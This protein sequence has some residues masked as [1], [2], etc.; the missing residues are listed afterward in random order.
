MSIAIVDSDA[1]CARGPLPHGTDAPCPLSHGR[2][3][4]GQRPLPDGRGSEKASGTATDNRCR[5][6]GVE[7][8]DRLRKRLEDYR[9]R[10]A[11]QAGWTQQF[12]PTGLAAVDAALP[13]GGLPCGA[14]TEILSDDAGVGAM[15]LALRIARQ[16]GSTTTATGKLRL[17]VP[18]SVHSR[19]HQSPDRKG[20][21]QPHEQWNSSNQTAATG[22]GRYDQRRSA[23]AG[24]PPV[25]P[26][27]LSLASTSEDHGQAVLAH[28][29]QPA[30][31]Y[32]DTHTAW[33]LSDGRG[34]DMSYPLPHGRG[35][36][37]HRNSNG[38]RAV[39][40][41]A[42]ARGSDAPY[43]LP[44]DR[45]SD[46]RYPLSDPNRHRNGSDGRHFVV[47]VDTVGDFYPPAAAQ[48]GVDLQRLTVVRVRRGK[49]AF[50]AVEQA[51]RCRAV[52][53]VIAPLPHL[54]ESQSRRLQLAAES[55]G[56]IG[57]ILRPARQRTKSFAAVRMHITGVPT[58]EGQLLPHTETGGMG[59]RSL[60][61]KNRITYDNYSAFETAATGGDRYIR[62][63]GSAT[64]QSGSITRQAGSMTQQ[65]GL[66]TTGATGGLPASV[67][68][69]DQQFRTGSELPVAPD[70]AFDESKPG[71][72]RTKTTGKLRLPMPP[73]MQASDRFACHNRDA[74]RCRIELL[75]VR[76][77]MPVEPILVDLHHE[78][79]DVPVHPVPVD[80][81][82][83]RTG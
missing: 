15:T 49:E 29:T 63:A 19:S 52:G 66:T 25:A 30:P 38:C 14:V 75:T 1:V 11:R 3:T 24:E 62:Q 74:Y 10:R 2:G 57:L 83:A 27:E 73:D 72:L 12:V 4:D 21:D 9:R 17:P 60:P 37:T 61:V 16:V 70:T 45:G 32:T 55:T 44:D 76:E 64:R 71:T 50:W 46:M 31:T 28:A 6:Q 78:T 48:H 80:R 20:G 36:D 69:G 56:C 22:G 43:P 5:D 26:H 51:L 23:L 67:C 68:S 47:V 35:S 77:G 39:A 40:P 81:P 65:A 7:V 82:A 18:P 34:T 8:V 53:A 42:C 59:K 13:H 41:L 58:K 33:P 79:G 54:D